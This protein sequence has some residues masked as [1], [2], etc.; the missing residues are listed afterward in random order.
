M[1]F[2]ID[3]GAQQQAESWNQS[4]QDSGKKVRV[5]FHKQPVFDEQKS[6][7]WIE[8]REALNDDGTVRIE[9]KR[10]PGA[11][12]PIYRDADFIRKYSPGDPTNIID[13]EVWPHDIEEFSKEWELYQKGKDQSSA[14]TPL[15]MLPGINPAKIEEYKAF[16]RAPVRT[17][18]DLANLSDSQAGSFMGVLADR[19]R[20]RDW[21]SLAENQ[22]PIVDL[23]N[24]VAEERTKN[25]AQAQQLQEL[26]RQLAEMR[27]LMDVATAPSSEGEAKGQSR[28]AKGQG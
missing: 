1:S 12:R 17:I 24:Q 13:R 23:R 6:N 11:G 21:M 14:G 10:H 26:Q 16:P 25:E 3:P 4:W 7:G 15:E 28:K 20:A 27:S 8:E 19:Q 18:E 2:V 5:Q 22:A 9:K